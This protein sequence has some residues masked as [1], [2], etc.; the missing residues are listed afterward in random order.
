[1]NVP[2]AIATLTEI[3]EDEDS[4]WEPDGAGALKLGIEALNAWGR[5]RAQKTPTDLYL[6]PGED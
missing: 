4:M 6:L 2:K 5:Y 3:L 1:M